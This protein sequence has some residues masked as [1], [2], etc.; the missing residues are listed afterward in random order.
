MADEYKMPFV[1]S[2]QEMVEM[3]L[4]MSCTEVVTATRFDGN[5]ITGTVRFR[6]DRE[7]GLC[8]V[9]PVETTRRFVSEILATAIDEVGDDAVTDGVG[10]MANIVAGNVK[11]VLSRILH[12]DFQYILPVVASIS[13]MEYIDAG[14]EI[15]RLSTDIGA[16]ELLYWFHAPNR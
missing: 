7:G 13:K 3:M 10:E 8:L 16:F 11:A 14:R 6:G 4:G 15:I 1:A 12:C 9:F 2:T 5:L